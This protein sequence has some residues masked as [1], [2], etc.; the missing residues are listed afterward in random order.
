MNVAGTVDRKAI[1]AEMPWEKRDVPKTL[2]GLLS[3]TTQKFP[4]HNAISYQILSG[5][6][7]KAETLSWTAFHGRVTQAANRIDPARN[8]CIRGG[9]IAAFPENRCGRKDG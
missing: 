2:Y 4:N 7:D 3:N 8:R 9:D 6:K 1:E 5:P